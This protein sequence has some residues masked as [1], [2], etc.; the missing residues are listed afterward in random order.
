MRVCEESKIK[1]N[2]ILLILL[3]GEI[4]HLAASHYS[5]VSYY[6][7]IFLKGFSIISHHCMNKDE[8]FI[9][10]VLIL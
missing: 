8:L 6:V 4:K 3:K 1:R 7:T 5:V 10:S 2:F 9:K